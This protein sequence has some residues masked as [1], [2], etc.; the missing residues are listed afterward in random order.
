[1]NECE[2][3]VS[4]LVNSFEDDPFFRW[5]NSNV[6]ERRQLLR[7]LS[8]MAVG[9]ASFNDFLEVDEMGVLIYEPPSS[10]LFT[11]ELSEEWKRAIRAAFQGPVEFLDR[12]NAAMSTTLPSKVP[13]WY[14]K[15][16]AVPNQIRGQGIGSALL[17]KF[18]NRI[19][20]TSQSLFLHTANP[21]T[22]KFY[23]RFGFLIR[24]EFICEG[25][26]PTVYTLQR[27]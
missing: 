25:G 1:M 14:L 8:R 16:L 9:A 26:G 15:Y 18:L 20:R 24:N 11:G 13:F 7:T 22:L 23:G 10:T 6:F 2:Q 5:V 17:S 19:D 27:R 3:A 4:I 12:Y 21:S